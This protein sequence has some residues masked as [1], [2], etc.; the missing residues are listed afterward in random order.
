VREMWVV[1]DLKDRLGIKH[2]KHLKKG[3]VEAA[4]M[5]H[6]PHARSFSELSAF[7]EPASM[8]NVGEKDPIPG[9]PVEYTDNPLQL[10]HQ[11]SPLLQDHSN[12]LAD[13][14]SSPEA[15]DSAPFDT[16]TPS[17]AAN[18]SDHLPS[19]QAP[20]SV[21]GS[22]FMNR[23]SPTGQRQGDGIYEMQVRDRTHHLP[24][25]I[26]EESESSYVTVDTSWPVP[27]S[28]SATASGI[29]DRD[30]EKPYSE[31]RAL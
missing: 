18:G 31:A 22:T 16:H 10:R 8:R 4:P 1:G 17:S 15:S 28:R 12:L 23:F 24:E 7:D 30:G 2:K 14:P 29:S 25:R 11:P 27:R 5:F 19:D 20:F 13:N 26:Q 21:A 9:R 6:Q 3:D